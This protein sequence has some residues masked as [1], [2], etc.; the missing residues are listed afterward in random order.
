MEG[1]HLL[2]VFY[3]G[4]VSVNVIKHMFLLRIVNL[5]KF[6]CLRSTAS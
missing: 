5:S 3:L 4:I 1:A 2:P 6:F